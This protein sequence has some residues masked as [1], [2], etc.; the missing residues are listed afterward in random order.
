MN[1]SKGFKRKRAWPERGTVAAGNRT[2][3]LVNKSQGLYRLANPLGLSYLLAY[4][5]YL[6]TNMVGL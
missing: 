3:H 1:A 5:P 4:F 6:K 2:E